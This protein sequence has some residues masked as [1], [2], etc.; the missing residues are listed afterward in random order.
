MA[1]AP[2]SSEKTKG[3]ANLGIA[4]KEAVKSRVMKVEEKQL[5]IES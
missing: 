4:G 5:L 1:N 2:V 3:L